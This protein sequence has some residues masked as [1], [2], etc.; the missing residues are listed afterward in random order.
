[1]KI[2]VSRMV[3]RFAP[4]E[5]R[6][7]SFEKVNLLQLYLSSKDFRDA[8]DSRKYTYVDGYIVLNSPQC[9]EHKQGKLTI[10]DG[11]LDNPSQFCLSCRRMLAG[12]DK[13]YR[14]AKAIERIE[15]CTKCHPFYTDPLK[16][17]TVYSNA[18]RIT[19]F[20]EVTQDNVADFIGVQ[21][22]EPEDFKTA[23]VR[24]MDGN[25][26]SVELLAELTGLSAKTIQR[27]RNADER[28]D[29]RFVIAVCLAMKLSQWDSIYLVRLAGYELTT[30]M[31]D[32]IFWTILMTTE[33][34]TVD[35]CNQMLE[36]LGYKPL[37]KL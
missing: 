7:Y 15:V 34:N 6:E 8:I 32:R 18:K 33:E 19:A 1:M 27:M 21:L 22:T 24:Y 10:R 11:V 37:T 4:F 2:D 35:D 5:K 13:K 14:K 30:R 26:L 31:E 16:K 9:L 29:L 3:V 20:Q 25:D 12:L 17:K 36:R 23:L 28:P